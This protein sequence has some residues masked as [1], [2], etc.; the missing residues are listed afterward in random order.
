MEGLLK[1]ANCTEETM[2]A[3]KKAWDEVFQ[4]GRKKLGI[5]LATLKTGRNGEGVREE[6]LSE[7]PTLGRGKWTLTWI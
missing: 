4:D 5:G 6:E 7:S 3:K 2:Q 1:Y